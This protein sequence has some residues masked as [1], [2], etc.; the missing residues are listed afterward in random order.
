MTVLLLPPWCPFRQLTDPL[1]DFQDWHLPVLPPLISVLWIS[2][3]AR[4]SPLLKK[5]K[6]KTGYLSRRTDLLLLGYRCSHLFT[7]VYEV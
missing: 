5:K 7:Y 3:P 1:L 6:K 4:C 2:L